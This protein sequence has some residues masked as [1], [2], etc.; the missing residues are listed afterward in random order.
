M[1]IFP[2]CSW[3]A[4]IYQTI[5]F[6]I[7]KRTRCSVQYIVFVFID[8]E[9]FIDKVRGLHPQVLRYPFNIFLIKYGT[10][11]F[12]AIGTLQ[13]ICFLENFLMQVQHHI[14]KVFGFGPFQ[15]GK[16]FFIGSFCFN[17]GLLQLFCIDAVFQPAF[18]LLSLSA[19][20]CMA[21]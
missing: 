9:V 8:M 3:T 16:K 21:S 12:A 19:I 10:G 4:F 2:A 6:L 18:R 15:P 5:V 7:Q 20:F 11:G 14:I 17:S 1:R 13:A